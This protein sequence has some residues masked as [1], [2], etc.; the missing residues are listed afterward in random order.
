MVLH[1]SFALAEE[2]LEPYRAILGTDFIAYRN[3]VLRVL[4]FYCALTATSNLPSPSVQIAAAFHDL[5]IWTAGTFD[6]L[7]PS[8]KLAHD[9][10]ESMGQLDLVQEVTALIETHHKIRKYDGGLFGTVEPF[11]E[12]DFIDV[13]LGLLR[14]TVEKSF[15]N[16]VRSALPNAGFHWRLTTL[17][18][19]QFLSNPLRP[20][21]MFRW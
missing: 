20:L 2:I 3:H 10:L 6:Y 16:D 8:V 21:P 13:S 1:H 19:R 9:Y 11:G 17:T 18:A 12:A 15:I 4:N 7:P 14:F 5:G